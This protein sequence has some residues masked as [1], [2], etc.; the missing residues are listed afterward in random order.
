MTLG[1]FE[2]ILFKE[3]RLGKLNLETPLAR[4]GNTGWTLESP[5]T[6][7]Q[8]LK[9]QIQF[10]WNVSEKMKLG[11]AYRRRRRSLSPVPAT[12]SGDG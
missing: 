1:E 5:I 12:G 7:E 6:P 3:F 9:G 2:K 11:R 4:T 8:L 10:K